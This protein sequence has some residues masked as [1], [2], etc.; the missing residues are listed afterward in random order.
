MIEPFSAL[1]TA[2]PLTL[3][4]GIA[5]FM[6]PVVGLAVGAIIGVYI[7]QMWTPSTPEIETWPIAQESAS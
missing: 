6:L 4:L 2:T 3:V 7:A 5:V 1:S